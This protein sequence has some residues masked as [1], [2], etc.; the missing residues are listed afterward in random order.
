[1]RGHQSQSI[2]RFLIMFI[3]DLLDILDEERHAARR[4]SCVAGQSGAQRDASKTLHTRRI[5]EHRF[6]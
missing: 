6:V 5:W 3:Y 2:R 1:M 4:T